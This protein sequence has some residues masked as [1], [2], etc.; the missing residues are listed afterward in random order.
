M[1][2]RW[3]LWK[4]LAFKPIHTWMGIMA[5]GLLA[6]IG[7]TGSV[8]VFRA[9]FERAALPKGGPATGHTARL[10]V[11][12]HEMMK[13][14]PAARS[15]SSRPAE[16]SGS[17]TSTVIFSRASRAAKRSDTQASSCSS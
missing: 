13:L 15:A 11:S 14:W 2:S 5:G 4:R 16:W 3:A 10:D 9:D 12:A 8:I 7:V 6:V 1:A 17:L